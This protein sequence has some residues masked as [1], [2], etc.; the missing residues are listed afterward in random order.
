[1][2][3]PRTVAATALLCALA[4]ANLQPAPA[5]DKITVQHAINS[6]TAVNWPDFVATTLGFNMRENLDVQTVIMPAE[7]IVAALIGGSIQ[8]GLANAT[9]LALS[10]DKGANVVAVGVGA[11]NQPYHF[12]SAPAAK[13]FADLKGKNIALAD[14]IDIYTDVVRQILKKNGLNMET[15][16][17]VI[18]GNGQN[19]RYAAILSGAI[20]AGLFSSPADADL[21]A[22]GYN[23]LAFT[24]DYYPN[25]TLSV[26]AVNRAWADAHGDV[27]R[28]FL[29]ARSNAIK[30]LYNPANEA[31]AVQILM[32]QT[33]V[34]KAAADAAYDYYIRKGKIFPVD[35]CV[36]RPGL[37]TLMRLMKAAGR[38]QK[39][40]AG[41][42]GKLMDRQWCPR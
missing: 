15:D 40:G 34:N 32:D 12:L 35:G 9:Q 11:D 22:R 23:S 30:W 19:Q 8:V 41:D 21:M 3:V 20:Q 37:D 36:R 38:L 2:N 16:M 1:M 5:D 6:V 42:A 4:A 39:L 27:L 31:Q 33:K 18:Y 26:N 17:N 29:T 10:D 25:L 28:R 7:S 13:T 24:P 14:S